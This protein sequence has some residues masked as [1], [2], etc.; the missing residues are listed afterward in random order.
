MSDN[1]KA[2]LSVLGANLIYGANYSIAKKIMPEY[3]GPFGYI[4][5]RVVC[6]LILFFIAG[7]FVKEKIE[8]KFFKKSINQD[9][10]NQFI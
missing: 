7:I 10:E 2:H 4:V 1:L 3:I 9:E 5:V 8:K 6:A